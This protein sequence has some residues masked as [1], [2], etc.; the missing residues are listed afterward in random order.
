[1]VK[2][3]IKERIN[4]QT[5]MCS[6]EGRRGYR[7]AVAVAFFVLFILFRSRILYILFVRL[8]CFRAILYFVRFFCIISFSF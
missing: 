3:Y 8:P 2:V 6:G 4:D 1:M 7:F 5:T